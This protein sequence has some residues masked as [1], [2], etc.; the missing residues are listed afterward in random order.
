MPNREGDTV[1]VNFDFRLQR[2]RSPEDE[3]FSTRPRVQAA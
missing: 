1:H 3:Q 2:A